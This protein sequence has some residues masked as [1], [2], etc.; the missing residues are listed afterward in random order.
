MRRDIHPVHVHTY[1]EPTTKLPLR[2]LLHIT[3]SIAMRQLLF[4]LH[5]LHYCPVLPGNVPTLQTISE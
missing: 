2:H 4:C 5:S 1:H 3:V